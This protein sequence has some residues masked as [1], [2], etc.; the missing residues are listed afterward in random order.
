MVYSKVRITLAEK[1]LDLAYT[2]WNLI[3]TCIL[4]KYGKTFGLHEIVL[5]VFDQSLQQELKKIVGWKIQLKITFIVGVHHNRCQGHLR[6]IYSI[7]PKIQ[8]FLGKVMIQLNVVFSN[9]F[10]PNS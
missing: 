9:L 10:I 4:K 5:S 2:K 3:E 7:C 1:N 8:V 6:P